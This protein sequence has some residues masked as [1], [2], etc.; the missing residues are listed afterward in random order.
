[1]KPAQISLLFVD[2]S[3]MDVELAVRML[4]REGFALTWARVEDEAGLRSALAQATPDVILSDFSMPLFSGTDALRV[5]RELQPAVPF[6]FLSGSIGEDRAHQARGQGV[7]DCI[8]KGD[9]EALAMA[10]RRVLEAHSE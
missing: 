6:I 7:S 2:D 4:K 1:M 9:I 5:A 10:L 8:E 3:D